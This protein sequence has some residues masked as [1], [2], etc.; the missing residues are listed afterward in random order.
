MSE[1]PPEN[2]PWDEWAGRVQVDLPSLRQYAQAVYAST[3]AYLASL[4][5]ADLDAA[6]QGFVGLET[7]GSFLTGLGLH[8]GWHTGEI[9]AIKGVQGNKGY[10]F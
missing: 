2:P 3:D 10:P 6:F 1:P 9:S 5:P 8:A 4:S 7:L